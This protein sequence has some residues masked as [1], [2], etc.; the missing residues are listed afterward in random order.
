[1]RRYTDVVA[2]VTFGREEFKMFP[3]THLDTRKAPD[4][5]RYRGVVYRFAPERAH[6]VKGWYPWININWRNPF[7]MFRWLALRLNRKVGLL[8]YVEPDKDAPLKNPAAALKPVEPIHISTKDPDKVFE[9]ATPGFMKGIILS[10]V[11]KRY[12][13]KKQFQRGMSN[14]TTLVVLIIVIVAVVALLMATGRI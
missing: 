2:V 1:M 3:V 13:S 7:M 9:V 6:L 4:V 8:V 11:L 14:K 10:P 5:V 12:Q